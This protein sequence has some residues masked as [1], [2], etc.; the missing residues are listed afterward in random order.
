[1]SNILWKLCWKKYWDVV[2]FEA[3]VYKNEQYNDCSEW[4]CSGCV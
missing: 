2:V 1:M 3:N 4:Y